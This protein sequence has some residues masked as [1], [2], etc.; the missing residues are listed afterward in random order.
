M[1][2]FETFGFLLFFN[3]QQLTS[4]WFWDTLRSTLYRSSST[5]S[6]LWCM[7]LHKSCKKSNG[8]SPVLECGTY[9]D[10]KRSEREKP[11]NL[12]LLWR[13]TSKIERRKSLCQNSFSLIRLCLL[14]LLQHLSSNWQQSSLRKI[15][16]K[17]IKVDLKN[18]GCLLMYKNL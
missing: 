7:A 8:C 5:T 13:Q 2:N 18:W 6:I 10:R 4:F 3:L 9:A 14:L 15:K 11:N 16:E 12:Q 1:Q 17:K